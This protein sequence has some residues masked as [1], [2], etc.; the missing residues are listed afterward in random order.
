MKYSFTNNTK[1]HAKPHDDSKEVPWL[2]KDEVTEVLT[3]FYETE[4]NKH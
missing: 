3:G 1:I 4:G 2:Y